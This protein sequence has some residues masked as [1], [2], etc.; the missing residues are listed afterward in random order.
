MFRVFLV[1]LMFKN[2]AL[3]LFQ[4]YQNNIQ[5]GKD[6][7]FS[8]ISHEMRTPLNALKGISDLLISEQLT[9]E[10]ITEY[11]R[12]MNYSANH[13]LNLV[14]DVFDYTKINLGEF[15]L[16]EQNLNVEENINFAFNINKDTA[17]NKGISY[18]LIKDTAVP[19]LVLSD[20]QRFNQILMNLISN[21]IKFT[22]KGGVKV[23]YGGKFI[24][25]NTVFMLKIMVQDT[26]IGIDEANLPL[27]FDKYF[28]AKNNLN[29]SGIG[30]GL[31]ITKKII[32]MMK[33]QINVHS[34]L[35]EGTIFEMELPLKVVIEK[36]EDAATQLI[37]T[38]NKLENLRIL[39]VE[40]NKINQLVL[41]KLL[42]NNIKNS[43]ILIANDGLEAI[44]KMGVHY[45]D[46]VLMD[47]IMPNMNGLDTSKWIRNHKSSLINQLPIIALTANI[48][49]NDLKSCYAS[50]I[51]DV[52][53]KPYEINDIIK[54][55]E[56]LTLNTKE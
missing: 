31:F 12:I 3:E 26:G 46:I 18:E 44:E 37:N 33:G 32:E 47:L 38:G 53:T 34:Q 25:D 41:H 39:I 35:K 45:F 52:I 17:Q 8:T 56:K 14:N 22:N 9:V 42:Q 30:L 23:I 15:R 11:Q 13:L 21:A 43:S 19:K 27:I 36:I 29:S 40:D 48:W 50:G 1:D 20:I 28:Q 54:K 49:R 2:K 55:M 4:E 6:T 5:K 51:N 10:E 16:V 24:K 7:F